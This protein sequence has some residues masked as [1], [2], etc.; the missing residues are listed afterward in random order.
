MKNL[1]FGVKP[2][3]YPKKK[4]KDGTYSKTEPEDLGVVAIWNEYGTSNAPPRPAFRMG[5]EEAQRKNKPMIQAQ[6]KNIAQRVLSGRKSDLD[7]SLTVLLTQIG[8]SAKAETRRIIREGETVGNAPATIARKGF[9]HPLFE[10]GLLLDNVEY[11][12]RDE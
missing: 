8:R 7:K 12:V 2:V 3:K 5:L 9:D 6:L 1:I 11:E 4:L 10:T